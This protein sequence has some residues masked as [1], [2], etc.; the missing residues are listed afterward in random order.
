MNSYL[1]YFSCSM[2]VIFILGAALNFALDPLGY[3]RNHGLHPGTFLGNRV[4]GD[5]RAAFDLS[6]DSYRPDTVIAGN[7]RVRHG[8]AVDDARLREQL[9]VMLNLGLPGADIGE[10]DRYIRKVLDNNPRSD[11]M[12]GLDFEQFLRRRAPDDHS[13]HS[14]PLHPGRL[15][16]DSVRNLVSALWSENAFR[17]SAELLVMPHNSTL[18]GGSNT[19]LV[20]R[21]V[22]ISGHRQMTRRTET[23]IAQR[24]SEVDQGVFNAR[25]A[26]LGALLTEVC[27][28]G[29][30]TRLFISPI[31]VRQLLLIREL[32]QLGLYLSWKARLATMVSQ[33]QER[34][35]AV[36]L[37]DF[38]VISEHTSEPFPEPGDRQHRMQWYWESSHY[39]HRMGH[40]IIDRLLTKEE[41][42]LDFGITVTAD[43][44]S[45]LLK[46]ERNKLNALAND[47]PMLV[48]EI[49]KM[50]SSWR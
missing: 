45:G 46:E 14:A 3:F 12:I 4:W 39:N 47:Q 6:I 1:R 7:S 11:L 5:E 49:G 27:R 23:R 19:E 25:V 17:A 26:T 13:G 33:L 32:G 9:G 20:H 41:G 36:K 43:N 18:D 29:T 37:T 8:F 31:H 15:L 22:R 35:C 28:K 38:S 24:Y 42:R 2:L 40:M 21:R 30:T 44:V 10:L 16:P 48:K 34:D 50:A